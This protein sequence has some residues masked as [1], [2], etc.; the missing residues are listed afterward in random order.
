MKKILSFN[1][2]Q[3]S[4]L[5]LQNQNLYLPINL[6]HKQ[7]LHLKPFHKHSKK[8]KQ[9]D[10]KRDLSQGQQIQKKKKKMEKKNKKIMIKDRIHT[11][12]E[13]RPIPSRW[14][15]GTSHVLTVSEKGLSS[16]F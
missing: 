3:K 6:D 10:Y 7:D 5:L 14:L 13:R 8:K 4:L 9:V 16:L 15:I 11:V 1:Q 2:I 12:K